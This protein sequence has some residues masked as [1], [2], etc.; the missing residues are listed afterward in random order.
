MNTTICT[1][2]EGDYHHGLCAL[3]NSL[4]KQGFEGR[5]VAGFRGELPQWAAGARTAAF[6]AW[7]DARELSVGRCSLWLLP[8]RTE[9]HF[10][11]IK[12]DFML[13]LLRD[14]RLGIES[15]LYLDPDICVTKNWRWFQDWLRCGI[16][17]CEDVNSPLSRDHPRRAGWRRYFGARGLALSWRGNEYVNGGCVGVLP[18][19]APFLETWIALTQHM[20]ELIGGLSTAK[21]DN[22]Q[23]FAA[24]G[25]ADCFDCSDQDALNAAL[26]LYRDAPLSILPRIAMAFEPGEAFLPHALGRKKPWRKRYLAEM[27]SGLPPTTADKAFW[28]SVDGPLHSMSSTRRTLSQWSV[29]ASS[30]ISRFYRR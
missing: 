25:F 11:N 8:M 24:R 1:L 16:A 10:T 9:A 29:A 18:E 17:L 22:A 20:A 19:H 26:E 21:V 7:P 5:I 3:T 28:S 30:A 15:L 2:F 13:A 4:L 14:A 23:G 27:A 12:P 6:G